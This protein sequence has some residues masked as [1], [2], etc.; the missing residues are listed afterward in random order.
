MILLR[1]LKTDNQQL[2]E[3]LINAGELMIDA[4]DLAAP[5]DQYKVVESIFAVVVKDSESDSIRHMAAL[6][7]KKHPAYEEIVSLFPYISKASSEQ[8]RRTSIS[9][10]RIP[11][12][13]KIRTL[14]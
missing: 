4:T 11:S 12:Q 6:H 13:P 14:R 5:D 3:R 1:S 9:K 10:I 2:V 7:K 8:R